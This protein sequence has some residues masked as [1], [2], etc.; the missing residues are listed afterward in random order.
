MRRYLL[1]LTVVTLMALTYVQQRVTLVAMGYEVE[2]LRRVKEDLLDQHRVLQYNVLTLQSPVI[3]SQ[4]LTHRDVVLSPPE[5][6]EVLNRQIQRPISPPEAQK[7]ARASEVPWMEHLK[8]IAVR[9]LEGDKTAVAQPA[10]ENEKFSAG[11]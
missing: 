1:V 7:Q 5:H 3:L 6:I 9:W 10:L 4:R 2:K 11:M 8:Q